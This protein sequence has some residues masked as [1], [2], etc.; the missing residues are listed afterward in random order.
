[1]KRVLI[2]F[3]IIIFAGCMRNLISVNK[4]E[5][6]SAQKTD[7]E[8]LAEK[9]SEFKDMLSISRS[10]GDIRGIWYMEN[11]DIKQMS[12]FLNYDIKPTTGYCI[13]VA[14]DSKS[15][16]IFFTVTDKIFDVRIEKIT[17]TKYAML[18]GKKRRAFEVINLSH[19]LH[20]DSKYLI[21]FF[22]D[23]YKFNNKKGSE[24]LQN[25]SNYFDSCT[26][27]TDYDCTVQGCLKRIKAMDD[28][29]DAESEGPLG[30]D[31]K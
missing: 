17:D 20:K 26:E 11:A 3:S 29:A 28:I 18:N 21:W 12:S 24:Q 9:K 6:F 4:N 8:I 5:L 23:S 19:F 1:M 22:E 25:G 7:K 31:I 14:G 13:E 10:S 2:F 15:A 27:N 30:N 16:K